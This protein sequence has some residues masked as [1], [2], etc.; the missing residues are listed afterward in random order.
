[1]SLESKLNQL[2]SSGTLVDVFYVFLVSARQQFRIR[3]CGWYWLKRLQAGVQVVFKSPLK[4]ISEKEEIL[5]AITNNLHVL[6]AYYHKSLFLIHVLI[7][8][9]S[10]C[11]L[12]HIR[13]PS[14]LRGERVCGRSISL[15][16]FPLFHSYTWQVATKLD[17]NRTLSSSQ[18]VLWD[19]IAKVLKAIWG[20][21]QTHSAFRFLKTSVL[22]KSYYWSGTFYILSPPNSQSC[23]RR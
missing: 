13:V 4:W 10:H 14:F 21:I 1:M 15:A 6:V 17:R 7:C 8:G 16:T 20:G 11:C 5:V 22:F 23:P 2:K 18:K 3:H 12:C 9:L 19:S